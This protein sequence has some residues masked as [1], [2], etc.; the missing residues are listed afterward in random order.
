MRTLERKYSKTERIIA[1]AK[2]S[3]TVYLKSVLLA[4]ILGV[5]IAVVW[6]FSAQIE[7]VFTKGEGSATILTDEVMRYVLLGAGI[8][9]LISLFTQALSLY[10]KELIVTENQVVFRFGVIAVKN[11]TIPISEIVI[12]ETTHSFLQRLLGTGT[13]SIVSDAEKPYKVKGVRKADR[14]TRRIMKQVADT[15]KE[16]DAKK[17][18]IKLT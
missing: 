11:I 2:F 5:I 18:Q 7:H 14:L 3:S 6:K 4:L 13:I 12:I 8:V 1:K 9:V 15:R 16:N 10:A 17:I